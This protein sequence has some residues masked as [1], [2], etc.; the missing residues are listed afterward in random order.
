MV[1]GHS[2][3]YLIFVFVLHA[4]FKWVVGIYYVPFMSRTWEYYVSM[5]TFDQGFSKK[6]YLYCCLQLVL[7][8]A[9]RGWEVFSWMRLPYC[10]DLQWHNSDRRLVILFL[11]L[12]WCCL[13]L[14]AY[15][16]ALDSLNRETW[17]F[18]HALFS[19]QYYAFLF[20]FGVHEVYMKSTMLC[21]TA[22]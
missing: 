21:I 10:D 5:S 18:H 17:D 8:A 20:M 9:I 3:H 4:H 12:C 22:Y 2:S 19:C 14:Y 15:L 1:A 7:C 13:I 11:L 16:Q 6:I